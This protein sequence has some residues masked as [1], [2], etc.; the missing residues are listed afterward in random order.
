MIFA[1]YYYNIG[2]VLKHTIPMGIQLNGQL[3][4]LWEKWWIQ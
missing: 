3:S 4:W 2:D 1:V